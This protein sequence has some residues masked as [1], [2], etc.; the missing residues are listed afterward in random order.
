MMKK[1]DIIKKKQWKKYEKTWVNPLT[2]RPL[3]QD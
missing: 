1:K 3:A 2:S